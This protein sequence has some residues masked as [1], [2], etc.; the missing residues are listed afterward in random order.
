MS[1]QDLYEQI[2]CDIDKIKEVAGYLWQKNWAECNGGNISV[3]LTQSL[4][5]FANDYNKIN[6]EANF[7]VPLPALADEIF[8]VT[9]AGK[10]MRDVGKDPLENGIVL[11]IKELGT[12]YEILSENN[13]APTSELPSHLS[14]HNYFKTNNLDKKVILH[15]HPTELIALTHCEP[16]K[17]P[18]NLTKMLWAMIPEARIVVPKGIGFA[19]Y[20]TPGTM[21]LANSTM[22]QLK[23]NDVV[24]WEKHGALAVG[25][26]VIECFDI[27]DTLTKSAQIYLF[28]RTAGFEPCGLSV[29][30]MKNLA[31]TYKLPGY[32]NI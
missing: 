15:T 13:V 10:R 21:A 28:A 23:H 20:E 32:R 24:L 9:G 1:N 6:R 5:S 17:D 16:F 22:K 7:F 25:E 3:N 12:G 18:Y 29:E 8:Y 30:Q 2:K 27:I 19:P 26:D 14:I 31:E 4:S 11:K